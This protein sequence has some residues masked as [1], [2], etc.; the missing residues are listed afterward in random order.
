MYNTTLK[1]MLKS[2]IHTHTHT[3]MSVKKK[4]Y[5]DPKAIGNLFMN[6]LSFL[7]LVQCKSHILSVKIFLSHSAQKRATSLSLRVEG[8]EIIKRRGAM[9]IPRVETYK[10]CKANEQTNQKEK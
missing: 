10:Y 1:T 3:V 7:S 6:L 4:N 2:C 8:S 9:R 5:E